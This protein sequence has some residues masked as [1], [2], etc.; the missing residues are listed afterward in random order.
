[1]A[2]IEKVQEKLKYCAFG[3]TKTQTKRAAK[4][5]IKTK[6]GDSE[7]AKELLAKQSTKM[8][9]EILRV[10]GMKQG[11]TGSVFK[12]REIIG[13]KKKAK[14]EAHAVKDSE[15]GEMV[16]SNE[17]IK[18]VTLKYC[19]NVLKN[20]EPEDKFKNLV[21]LKEQVHQMRMK[22]NNNETEDDITDEE[23]FTNVC[24]FESKKSPMYNFLVNTGLKFR[25]SIFNVCKRFINRGFPKQL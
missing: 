22:D 9:S 11:R 5:A 10:K 24:K 18:R 21:E 20:N 3:K 16:V 12:M 1:M 7:K 17:E 2:D 15:S 8:E 13:G 14:K 19:L 4:K 25:M 23:F 6:S